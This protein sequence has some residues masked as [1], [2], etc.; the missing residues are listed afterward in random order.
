VTALVLLAIEL[1]RPDWPGAWQ[2]LVFSVTSL[3]AGAG[4]ALA[5]LRSDALARLFL[6]PIRAEA[7]VFQHAQGMFVRHGLFRTRNR[8][9]LLILVSRFER[10]VI[11]LP[12]ATLE[13][14]VSKAELQR[15]VREVS[16]MLAGNRIC[17]GLCGGIASAAGL[18]VRAGFVASG[19]AANEIPDPVVEDGG[20][21]GRD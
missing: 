7:E 9:G 2:T 12:D 1:V 10:Q 3:G 15:I 11:I 18:V 13:T 16:Q 17:D 4:L 21:R 19:A 6:S 8:N 14:R 20:A 5:T